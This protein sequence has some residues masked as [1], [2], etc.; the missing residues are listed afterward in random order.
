MVTYLGCDDHKKNWDVHVK[1]KKI[2][3]YEQVMFHHRDLEINNS[4][5]IKILQL[6]LN[7]HR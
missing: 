7:T 1:A 2:R 3:K 5:E 6:S 4:K